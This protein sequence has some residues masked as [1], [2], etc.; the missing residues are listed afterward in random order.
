M[1][2]RKKNPPKTASPFVTQLLGDLISL[3]TPI[4]TTSEILNSAYVS[5]KIPP[6]ILAALSTQDALMVEEGQRAGCQLV[7]VYW[8]TGESALMFCSPG[9]NM[10]DPN[11]VVQAYQR[12]IAQHSALRTDLGKQA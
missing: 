4:L 6:G 8:P 11:M 10:P 9:S 1:T 7:H 5:D 2:R 12:G 3:K